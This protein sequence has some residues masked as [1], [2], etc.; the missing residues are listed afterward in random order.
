MDYKS[1][2]EVMMSDAQLKFEN[3]VYEAV[4]NVDIH[5]D[6][7]ELIKALQ[8][9]RQQYEKGWNDAL[10]LLKGSGWIS[11]RERLPECDRILDDDGLTLNSSEY[12]LVYG[13]DPDGD[14]VL[15]VANY[16]T[17]PNDPEWTE[18]DGT[19]TTL[20]D[21]IN[22]DITHWARIPRL[23]KEAEDGLAE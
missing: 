4:Q 17:D 20:Y 19:V 11:V 23:P 15:G 13:T 14:K 12:V 7:D 16:L 10:A 1:P 5:V 8:Y 2:I 22:C 21:A 9:D 3:G 6:R 18:W